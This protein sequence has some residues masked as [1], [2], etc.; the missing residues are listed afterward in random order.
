MISWY[1][2]VHLDTH[3]MDTDSNNLKSLNNPVH[4]PLRVMTR[5][6][7][8]HTRRFWRFCAQTCLHWSMY[9]MGMPFRPDQV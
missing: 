7:M 2:R 5:Q 4:L 8:D 9:G 3:L 1:K 6:T